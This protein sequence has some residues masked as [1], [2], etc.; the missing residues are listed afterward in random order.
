MTLGGSLLA[1]LG[2]FHEAQAAPIAPS[3]GQ[4]LAAYKT[5]MAAHCDLKKV[6]V[7]T[8]IEAR[9]LRNIPYALAGRAFKAKDLGALFAND[10]AWYHPK[11]RGS[12]RPLS[13]KDARCV[14]KLKRLERR[15]RHKL[16]IARFIEKIITRHP[17]VFLTLRKGSD[18][19]R[20]GGAHDRRSARAWSWSFSD[21]SACGGDGSSASKGDCAGFS[22]V[23]ELPKG[24]TDLQKID[25]M[26]TWSG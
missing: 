26:A 18:P 15:L 2:L 25:C 6:A 4:I 24:T 20:Y 11:K 14:T 23:C 1:L 3:K 13:R 16:P 5:L 21:Y 17:L 10:G 7:G 12:V 9:V 22:V 8:P 19:S